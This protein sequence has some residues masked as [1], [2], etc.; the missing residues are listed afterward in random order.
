MIRGGSVGGERKRSGRRAAG[1]DP[2][3]FFPL[4]STANGPNIS[5]FPHFYL[6]KLAFW[7]RPVT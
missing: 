3:D 2:E 1:G 5:A 7:R 4:S 6:T